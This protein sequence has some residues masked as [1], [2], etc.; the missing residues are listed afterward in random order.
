MV[1]TPACCAEGQGSEPGRPS[2]Q[3]VCCKFIRLFGLWASWAD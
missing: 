2:V 1:S 3:V